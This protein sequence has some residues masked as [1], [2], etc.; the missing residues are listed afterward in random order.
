M[1]SIGATEDTEGDS[2]ARPTVRAVGAYS[3][4][5]RRCHLPKSK[6]D[7]PITPPLNVR[8]YCFETHRP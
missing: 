8:T 1:Y 6:S 5:S 4:H 7:W 2:A 3:G